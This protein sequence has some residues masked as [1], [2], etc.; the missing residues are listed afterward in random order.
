MITTMAAPPAPVEPNSGSNGSFLRYV[1]MALAIA[2]AA[3]G[4]WSATSRFVSNEAT[5]VG[6]GPMES[7]DQSVFAGQTG[8]WIEHV[9]LLGGNGLIEIRYRILDV[10]KSEIVHDTELPPRIVDSDGFVIRYQRH[11]H[12]HDRVNRLG[13]TYGEEI[14]NIGRTISSGD[15]VTVMIGGYELEGVTVQ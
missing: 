2:V 14:V 10:D 1:V 12:S 6:L 15:V 7:V 11:E 3:V 5:P 8:V 13:A 4:G 9:A